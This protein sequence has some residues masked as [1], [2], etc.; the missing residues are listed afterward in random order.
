MIRKEILDALYYDAKY[1]GLNGVEFT[2]EDV[3][4][5]LHYIHKGEHI[6][7]AKKIILTN[8]RNSLY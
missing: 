7:D 4:N 2:D 5:V 1:Y 3:D 6:E 8:I